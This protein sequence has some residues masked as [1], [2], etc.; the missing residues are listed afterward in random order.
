M[1]YQIQIENVENKFFFAFVGFF[2]KEFLTLLQ[3]ESEKIHL[4]FKR[5]KKKKWAWGW[6]LTP[7]TKQGHREV[8]SNVSSCP[9]LNPIASWGTH[10]IIWDCAALSQAEG[11]EEEK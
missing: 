10:L 4:S 3:Q 9:N 2:L 5:K 8:D 1:K 11:G 6:N 7:D